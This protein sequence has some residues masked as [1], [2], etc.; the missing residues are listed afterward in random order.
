MAIDH[1]DPHIRELRIRRLAR[2]FAN[3]VKVSNMAMK[4]PDEVI[5]QLKDGEEQKFVEFLGLF[6][7]V[8]NSR[9]THWE[10]NRGRF[11]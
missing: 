6:G 9:G 2:Q 7:L 1:N 8:R 5:D 10:E 4:I 11:G 3:Q